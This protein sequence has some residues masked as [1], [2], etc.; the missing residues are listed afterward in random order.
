MKVIAV[1]KFYAVI[2][3]LHFHKIK[4]SK[5][6]PNSRKNILFHDFAQLSNF[7][8]FNINELSWKILSY[9]K[10]KACYYWKVIFVDKV[11]VV[12][13]RCLPCSWFIPVTILDTFHRP[14]FYLKHD[15]LETRFCLRLQV[16][17]THV[18]AGDRLAVIYSSQ[19]CRFH[20]K[21][22]T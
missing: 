8:R 17:P 15:V 21:K 13:G 6:V 22:E 5:H 18:S 7:I 14:V 3:E 20:L 4:F 11:T 10:I 19:L 2:Y 1:L 16:E 12:S 9:A